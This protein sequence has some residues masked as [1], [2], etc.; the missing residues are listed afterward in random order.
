MVRA[1]GY[2][3]N[4][5]AER[6]RM[7]PAMVIMITLEVYYLEIIQK[8]SSLLFLYLTDT[9]TRRFPVCFCWG[10]TKHGLGCTENTV[11]FTQGLF[12][13]L[14]YTDFLSDRVVSL[15]EAIPDHHTRPYG[16]YRSDRTVT[17]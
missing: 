3:R 17:R 2:F 8:T 16:S 13:E 1:G 15:S 7:G 11:M 12:Y 6:V 9:H 10:S 5:V 4:T 14:L